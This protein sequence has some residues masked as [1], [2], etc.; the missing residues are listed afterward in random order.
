MN[1]NN[2]PT[3]DHGEPVAWMHTLDNTEGILSNR[4][5]VV[6][7][8]SPNHPF[9]QPGKDYSP[10]FT[11]ASVPLYPA[12]TIAA[13]REAIREAHEAIEEARIA[14]FYEAG[15]WKAVDSCLPKCASALT[16]LQPFLDQ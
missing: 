16:K 14:I 13:M 7:D 15:T 4:P 9:G 10:E 11:V 3:P 1:T 8:T 2:T 12:A 6:F 5:M